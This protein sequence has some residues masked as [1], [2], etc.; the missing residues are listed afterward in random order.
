ML[1]FANHQMFA[2]QNWDH[3]SSR[4]PNWI[5]VGSLLKWLRRTDRSLLQPNVSGEGAGHARQIQ[6]EGR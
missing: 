5:A 3:A 6:S 4:I 1:G 2:S